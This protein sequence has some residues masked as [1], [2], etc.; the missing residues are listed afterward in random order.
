MLKRLL[1]RLVGGIAV[2]AAAPANATVVTFD[3][4]TAFSGP[5]SA[6]TAPFLRFEFD[7]E[8]VPGMVR[9][10]A[11]APGLHESEWVAN[12]HLNIDP[13]FNSSA[14]TFANFQILSGTMLQPLAFLGNDQFEA[15]GGGLFDLEFQ[16][17]V[18]GG[19]FTRR[20][21]R[22]ESFSFDLGGIPGLNA[23]S[24]NFLSIP[25]APNGVQLMSALIQGIGA[26][27]DDGFHTVPEPATPFLV[28]AALAAQALR[29]RSS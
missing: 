2:V 5:L 16:F 26:N 22:G 4:N 20:F 21:N 6:G 12:V 23:N 25:P 29:R 19:G 10:T 3:V 28:L 27:A 14:L 9:M 15:D 18:S 11:S 7:D 17:A 13:A 8:I 1:L 24:F